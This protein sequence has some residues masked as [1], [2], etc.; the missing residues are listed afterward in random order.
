MEAQITKPLYIIGE[1]IVIEQHIPEAEKPTYRMCEIKAAYWTGYQWEYEL[2]SVQK[3]VAEKYIISKFNLSV[4]T[5]T[6]GT[7][8][9]G[10]R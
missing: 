2:Y 10:P 4:Y 6:G 1:S 9:A 3:M 5:G 7:G 8:Y